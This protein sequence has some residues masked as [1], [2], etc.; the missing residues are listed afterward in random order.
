[1]FVAFPLIILWWYL[2]TSNRLAI[3]SRIS[4]DGTDYTA[5]AIPP[6]ATWAALA[7]TLIRM[8]SSVFRQS[9]VLLRMVGLDVQ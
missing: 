7:I 1:M 6:G 2:V 8:A 4:P 5:E 3:A 9:R